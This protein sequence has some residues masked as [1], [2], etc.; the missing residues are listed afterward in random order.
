MD[1]ETHEIYR[2]AKYYRL[3]GFHWIVKFLKNSPPAGRILRA[4]LALGAITIYQ[5]NALIYRPG[6]G[7]AEKELLDAAFQHI[8]RTNDSDGEEDDDNS[9]PIMYRRGLYFLS[10]IVSDKYCYR[11]PACRPLGGE[12]LARLYRRPNIG[13]VEQEFNIVRLKGS[14]AKA[15]P[16]R[17]HN[18]RTR[19]LDI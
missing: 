14:T 11:L 13:A 8:L 16:S 5:L 3:C 2:L 18:R 6:E 17:I 7:K 15:H 10:D 4:S 1:S 9:E 19:T 12:T